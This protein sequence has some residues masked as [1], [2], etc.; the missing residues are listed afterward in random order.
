MCSCPGPLNKN[1]SPTKVTVLEEMIRMMYVSVLVVHLRVWR[2][3]LTDFSLR[4]LMTLPIGTKILDK[5]SR[6][7]LLS[8]QLFPFHPTKC[9]T[10][11]ISILQTD[12]L[13][14]DFSRQ[15]FARWR[16]PWFFNG[17]IIILAAK[18]IY[19]LSSLQSSSSSAN[20]RFFALKFL[21]IIKRAYQFPQCLVLKI[22]F[23]LGPE[24]IYIVSKAI[25]RCLFFAAIYWFYTLI[26]PID[27]CYSCRVLLGSFIELCT[28]YG[29]SVLF[30][31]LASL[32]FKNFSV[33]FKMINDHLQRSKS[34][35]SLL[36]FMQIEA[37][38]VFKERKSF[39]NLFWT[40][41][42]PSWSVLCTTWK[43]SASVA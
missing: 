13:Y 12:W 37:V 35:I 43:I 33:F 34:N 20:R 41:F 26:T 42:D 10:A 24:T 5:Y 36:H 32:A 15:I 14:L 4:K 27:C 28:K 23:S 11:K 40:L 6:F 3:L 2:S 8:V 38:W 18:R 30:A 21:K 19:R 7:F 1:A 29:W 22:N 31:T 9:H 16:K 25:I 39:V 17:L